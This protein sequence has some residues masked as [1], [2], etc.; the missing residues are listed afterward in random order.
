MRVISK[1]ATD[2]D[3]S[4]SQT[5]PPTIA[6]FRYLLPNLPTNLYSLSIAVDSTFQANYSYKLIISSIIQDYNNFALF[7]ANAT[8]YEF[9]PNTFHGGIPLAPNT[10]IEIYAY[11]SQ[12]ASSDGH[13]SVSILATTSD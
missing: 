11:N 6:Q 4:A 8:S 2:I 1:V 5:I 9:V 13:F 3:V 10:L 7:P 12:G